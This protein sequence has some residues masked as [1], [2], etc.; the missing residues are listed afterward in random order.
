MRGEKKV[1]AT[2]TTVIGAEVKLTNA[3]RALFQAPERSASE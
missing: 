3:N 1:S 2:E